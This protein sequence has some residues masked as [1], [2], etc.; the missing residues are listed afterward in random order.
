MTKQSFL[1]TKRLPKK[2]HTYASKSDVWNTPL[3]LLDK[4]LTKDKCDLRKKSEYDVLIDPANPIIGNIKSSIYHIN[5]MEDL[6]GII[7]WKKDVKSIIT[8]KNIQKPKVMVKLTMD[9]CL[10]APHDTYETFIEGQCAIQQLAAME[11]A[12]NPSVQEANKAACAFTT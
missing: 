7:Q 4:V 9:C 6:R 11:V 10:G 2:S 5:G 1:S 3:P 8:G 12:N